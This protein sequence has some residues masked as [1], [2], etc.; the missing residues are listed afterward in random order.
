MHS[1]LAIFPRD[2]DL[3]DGGLAF[4]G[5]LFPLAACCWALLQGGVVPGIIVLNF[6]EKTAVPFAVLKL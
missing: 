1:L 5:G 2:M 6:P 3:G 4:L